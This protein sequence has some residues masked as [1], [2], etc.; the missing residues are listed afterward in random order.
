M[1]FGCAAVL[2]LLLGGSAASGE[3]RQKAHLW[4][5]AGSRPTPL[6]LAPASPVDLRSLKIVGASG[7]GAFL[8]LIPDVA[9]GA[10]FTTLKMAPDQ[11]A[12][13]FVAALRLRF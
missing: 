10:G 3:K 5:Q 13:Q 12:M 9:L 11:R 4:L 6:S 1:H 8:P 7:V 2:A